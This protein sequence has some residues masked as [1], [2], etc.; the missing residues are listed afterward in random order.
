MWTQVLRGTIPH[1]L[2]WLQ[3]QTIRESNPKVEQQENKKLLGL[4]KFIR[5]KLKKGQDVSRN[6]CRTINIK[7]SLLIKE[8]AIKTNFFIIRG[9]ISRLTKT[10]LNSPLDSWT[11][12]SCPLLPSRRF[13]TIRTR[14]EVK[15]TRLCWI[16][17]SM[18]ITDTSTSKIQSKVPWFK[19]SPKWGKTCERICCLMWMKSFRTR[20]LMGFSLVK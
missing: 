5:W 18:C 6:I 15:N 14:S 11:V 16:T 1:R 4:I 3:V 2:I 19:S 10:Q 17:R 13:Q 12:M 8:L 20:L 9:R 7:R